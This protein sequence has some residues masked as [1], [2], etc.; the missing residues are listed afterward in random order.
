[1]PKHASFGY[2]YSTERMI[3]TD[4]GKVP[5]IYAHCHGCRVEIG[6][7]CPSA[8]RF[9]LWKVA[10]A[11]ELFPI[12]SSSPCVMVVDTK[13]MHCSSEFSDSYYKR[14]K[15]KLRTEAAQSNDT[16]SV[17]RLSFSDKGVHNK[18]MPSALQISEHGHA[19]C[20]EQSVSSSRVAR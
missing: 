2:K 11:R 16:P 20:K 6:Q 1:M 5:C 12:D 10:D 9:T 14:L 17:A 19:H 3:S 4:S 8:M 15:A 18:A 7:R 13:G